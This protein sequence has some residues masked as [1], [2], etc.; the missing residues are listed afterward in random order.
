MARDIVVLSLENG[1]LLCWGCDVAGLADAGTLA[2]VSKE[3]MCR[4]SC[5]HLDITALVP[6]VTRW[7]DKGVDEGFWLVS[8]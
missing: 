1:Q 6:L 7:R 4:A 2:G 3:F 5:K 8:G